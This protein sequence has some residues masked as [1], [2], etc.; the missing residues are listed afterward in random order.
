MDLAVIA[1]NA[2][3]HGHRPRSDGAVGPDRPLRRPAAGLLLAAGRLSRVV[4]LYYPAS[5]YVHFMRGLPLIL[6]IFWIYFL[7]PCLRATN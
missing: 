1:D 3:L 5:L 2:A 7:S 6:V 4:W